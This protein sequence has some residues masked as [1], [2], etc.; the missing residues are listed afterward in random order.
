LEDS[1]QC[2]ANQTQKTLII[3]ETIASQIDHPHKKTYG[4]SEKSDCFATNVIAFPHKIVFD[5]HYNGQIM[6]EV[7]LGI[8]GRYNLLNALAA[9]T[10]IKLEHDLRGK[11]FPTELILRKLA[12]FQG[13]KRRF[14]YQIYRDDF[15][16]IDDYAHHP[17]E[18]SSFLSSVK[19]AFPEKQITAVFQPHLYSRTRDF[20]DE[21]AQSLS[22]ADQIILLD[23][24][25]ARE[26]PIPGITSD[27]L[28]SK[29][30][31]TEKIKLSKEAL[32][33]YLTAHKPEVLVTLGAGDIDRL[34]AEI[35][36]GFQK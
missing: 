9:F 20:A 26:E 31:K 25:P 21:F 28:L 18:I 8:P 1:F 13:V 32:I 30:A 5:L 11:D 17:Q 23:I 33:P 7:S 2:F 16:Y 35:V 10:A 29:I 19:S 14:D 4:F 3:H 36:K 12:L 6:K 34:V 27:W 15:V 22:I 24:Y